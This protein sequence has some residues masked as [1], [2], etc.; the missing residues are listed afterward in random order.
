[1]HHFLTHTLQ[2][3]VYGIYL[4][5]IAIQVINMARTVIWAVKNGHKVRVLP[6][7]VEW[8]YLLYIAAGMAI[9]YGINV[10]WGWSFGAATLKYGGFAL[11][12]FTLFGWMNLSL[13][14][15]WRS[16]VGPSLIEKALVRYYASYHKAATH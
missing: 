16:A 1:M 15:F 10:W 3:I 14:N 4:V 13:T 9:G 5:L 7:K 2:F 6:R 12:Y 8:L 11:V